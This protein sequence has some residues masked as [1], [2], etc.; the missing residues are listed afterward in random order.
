MKEYRI[1]YD[2]CRS[3]EEQYT[4]I[5]E[6]TFTQKCP[7]IL[8][9]VQLPEGMDTLV[10]HPEGGDASLLYNLRVTA[11]TDRL[12]ITSN[13][14]HVDGVLYVYDTCRPYLKLV[15]GKPGDHMELEFSLRMMNAG[16][17]DRRLDALCS[18]CN[19]NHPART[20]A[21][22]ELLDK[23]AEQ[24][25]VLD[26]TQRILDATAARLDEMDQKY[27]AIAGSKFW[28][29]TKPARKLVNA[30]RRAKPEQPRIEESAP[31]VKEETPMHRLGRRLTAVDENKLAEERKTKFENNVKVS[32]LVPLYNTPEKY[33]RE[34][35][36]SVQAQTYANWQLCLADASDE[37]HANVET[38]VKEMKG[39]D[40]RIV[41]SRLAENRGI[42]FNTNDC[43]KL[44]DGEFI[45]LLDHDD[46]LHP[47]AVFDAVKKIN[48]ENA[49]FVYTDEMSFLE[50]DVQDLRVVHYKTEFAYDDLLGNN[51]ICH[52]SVFRRELF[53]KAGMFRTGYDGAQ[54][55]DLFLRITALKPK[56]AH[57]PEVRYYW[58]AHE[59]STASSAGEKPY[60]VLA[61][62]KT[63]H[64]FLKSR[65]IEAEVDV[66]LPNG[67]AYR[68][69][70]PLPSNPRV[71]LI[72]PNKD[73]YSL[74]KNCIDSIF[75]FTE[76][77]NYEILIVDNGSTQASV[78]RYYEQLKQYG[79]VRVIHD[80]RPFNF[81]AMNN[82]AVSAAEGELLLFLNNDT[83][84]ISP[85]WMYE[86][87]S[88]AVQERIG[89]VGAELYYA[90][91][92][93]QHAGIIIGP[94]KENVAVHAFQFENRGDPGYMLKRIYVRDTSAVTAACMM[95]R[96]DLF[97]QQGGFDEKTFA[98]AY[99][100]VDF[101]LRLMKAGYTN[102]ITPWAQLYHYESA[103]RGSDALP[104]NIERFRKEMTAFADRYEELIEKGDP[105]Y[106]K[107]FVYNP[108]FTYRTDE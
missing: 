13:A 2:C 47:S 41:Y 28:N 7:H 52:F 23:I 45:A 9:Q 12:D 37:A 17:D 98:V 32:I 79:N 39:N 87:A 59:G 102:V 99:N 107:H 21:P 101:C 20:K 60:A 55:H 94:S 91:R 104:E 3:G 25:R 56:F 4:R 80:D 70:Y 8:R 67:C 57:V 100:D 68:I 74:L 53:E 1:V 84:V 58:R 85:E 86:M 92:T 75:L 88:L 90:N 11:Q 69:H 51:Y 31:A 27:A 24:Q 89:A 15:S 76:Y 5:A 26:E 63:I 34:L 105:Y 49:D 83:E 54:D 93:V 97:T 29:A 42:A 40:D 30:V 82:D 46:L 19:P 71:T 36:E 61:G 48:E 96:K 95:V 72:I 33:L 78:L 10:I 18:F 77:D 16:E 103:S 73:H 6:D 62:I 35:I 108:T 66:T 106:S 81:A 14:A 22:A 43:F 65:G 64:D 50:D 44:A 38:A